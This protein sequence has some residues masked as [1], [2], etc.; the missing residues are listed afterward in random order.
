AA[1]RGEPPRSRPNAGI[2][3]GEAVSSLDLVVFFP[4]LILDTLCNNECGLVN[5]LLFRNRACSS[6]RTSRVAQHAGDTPRNAEAR[7]RASTVSQ[8]GNGPAPVGIA[9]E[10]RSR[11]A[12]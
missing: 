5:N 4:I 12:D 1:R 9:C 2:V 8:C 11:P 3:D 6:F 10:T 7:P